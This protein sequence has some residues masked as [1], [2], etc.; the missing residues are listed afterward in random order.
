MPITA[1]DQIEAGLDRIDW[2]EEC[3]EISLKDGDSTDTQ[4]G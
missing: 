3:P 1:N 2:D 4:Q